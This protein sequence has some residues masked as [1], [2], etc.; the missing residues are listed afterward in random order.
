MEGFAGAQ[1][2]RWFSKTYKEKHPEVVKGMYS[3]LTRQPVEGYIGSCNALRE[4]DYNGLVQQIAVPVMCLTGSKDTSTTPQMVSG[5]A[6]Q[7]PGALYHELDG[8]GHLPC[9]DA[10][11]RFLEA[12]YRFMEHIL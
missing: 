11:E 3:M 4:S 8:S 9:I 2:E 7:I 5:L 10:P 1:M 6:K 12:L